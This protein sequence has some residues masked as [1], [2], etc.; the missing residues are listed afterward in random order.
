LCLFRPSSSEA[1]IGGPLAELPLMAAG[2]WH[3]TAPD[4]FPLAAL[5]SFLPPAAGDAAATA[6]DAAAAAATTTAAALGLSSATGPCSRAVG[7]YS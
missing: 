2:C 6:S 4:Y 7:G 3:Y 5:P 1:A